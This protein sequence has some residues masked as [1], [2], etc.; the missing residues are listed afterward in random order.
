VII[1]DC[2][3][4]NFNTY[5]DQQGTFFNY[6]YGEYQCRLINDFCIFLFFLY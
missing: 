4:S 2:D 5:G 6:Y 3:D 1:L